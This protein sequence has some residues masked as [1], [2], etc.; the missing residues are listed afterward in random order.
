[1][2]YEK[3]MLKSIF[4]CMGL[5]TGGDILSLNDRRKVIQFKQYLPE[6]GS[7]LKSVRDFPSAKHEQEA[8]DRDVNREGSS[9]GDSQEDPK[10][11]PSDDSPDIKPRRCDA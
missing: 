1:M 2:V 10:I 11:S 5:L 9:D 6:W 8:S 3:R 4:D 7:S